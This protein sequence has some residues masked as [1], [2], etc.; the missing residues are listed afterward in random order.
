MAASAGAVVDVGRAHAGKNASGAKRLEERGDV[1]G[2]LHAHL[3]GQE[4]VGLPLVQPEG[5]QIAA[6]PHKVGHRRGVGGQLLPPARRNHQDLIRREFP[7]LVGNHRDAGE[8]EVTS[9]DGIAD[10]NRG[11]TDGRLPG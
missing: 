9:G 3:R 4:G 11:P 10:V 7:A 2:L 8:I 1:L 5:Q 6:G